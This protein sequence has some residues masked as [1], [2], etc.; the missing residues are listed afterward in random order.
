MWSWEKA[1][2]S[3]RANRWQ[4][5]TQTQVSLW[6]IYAHLF[7]TYPT[8]N[9]D[10]CGVIAS[11]SSNF[12]F[13]N[14]PHFLEAS[15]YSRHYSLWG[16]FYESCLP[17]SSSLALSP[18]TSLMCH[19]EMLFLSN[20]PCSLFH[21][22]HSHQF[23]SLLPPFAIIQPPSVAFYG[24]M[25]LCLHFKYGRLKFCPL[26]FPNPHPTESIAFSGTLTTIPSYFHTIYVTSLTFSLLLQVR[27]PEVDTSLLFS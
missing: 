8:L 14:L 7:S 21:I 26:K 15:I 4:Y 1:E 2:F 12:N 9:G 6:F 11:T 10:L 3:H 27:V 25:S 18:L 23:L 16:S 19:S 24:A 5:E 22:F 13:L 20:S 17:S